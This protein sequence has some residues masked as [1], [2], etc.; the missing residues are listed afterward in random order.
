MPRDQV[1]IETGREMR[2]HVQSW[3][4][5]QAALCRTLLTVAPFVGHGDLVEIIE[6]LQANAESRTC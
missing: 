1:L 6:H 5:A 3:D 2:I 4:Q